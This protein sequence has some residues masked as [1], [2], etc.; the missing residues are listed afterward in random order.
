MAE[1][2]SE[3]ESV[4]VISPN[5]VNNFQGFEAWAVGRIMA[6]EKLNREAMYRVFRS[7]WFMKEEVNFVA[8]NEDAIIV[9]FGCLE[10]RSRILNLM[11][12]LFDSCLFAI[13]PFIKVLDTSNAI[14]KLAAIDWKDRNG[15]WTKFLSG[16]QPA[17]PRAM[18]ILCWNCR[19]IRN[20]AT[21]CELKQLLVANDPEVIFLC[22]IKVHTNKL[23]SIRSKSRIEGCFV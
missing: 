5:A 4:Q 1:E 10:D 11:P 12:W 6:K 21:V 7:L 20:L 19:G 17:P 15:S 23:V 14:G 13:M 16:W 18:R 3:E 2:F 9:K 22:E 8:L